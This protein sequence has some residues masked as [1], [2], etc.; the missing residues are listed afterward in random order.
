MPELGSAGGMGGAVQRVLQ[1]RQPDRGGLPR[2]AAVRVLSPGIAV[3]G[4]GG[5]G[6]W[7]GAG[8]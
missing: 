6:V 5:E 1:V 4:R 8:L 2:R 3:Q 7:G